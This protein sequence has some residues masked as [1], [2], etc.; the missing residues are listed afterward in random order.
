M[1]E[2]D[3]S[4]LKMKVIRHLRH[5]HVNHTPRSCVFL[6]FVKL[7]VYTFDIFA[8]KKFSNTS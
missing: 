1:L 6:L 8:K 7:F 5:S 4:H 3:T 2:T